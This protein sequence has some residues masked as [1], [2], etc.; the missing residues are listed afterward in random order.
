MDLIERI[1]CLERSDLFAFVEA[2]CLARA[3]T[4]LEEE[5]VP[6]ARTIYEPDEPADFLYVLCEGSPVRLRL[7]ELSCVVAPG[8]CFGYEEVLSEGERRHWA[9]A[10]GSCLL[11]KLDAT[12][13]RKLL[14]E[15]PGLARGAIRALLARQLAPAP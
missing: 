12:Q 1:A 11:L 5:S 8:Q 7:G 2:E 4:A 10:E 13:A 14:A 15:D 9:R 6:A 3:A